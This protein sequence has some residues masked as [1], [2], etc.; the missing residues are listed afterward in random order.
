MSV[1]FRLLRSRRHLVAA[2]LAAGVL[3]SAPGAAIAGQFAPSGSHDATAPAAVAEAPRR[4][5]VQVYANNVENLKTVDAVCPGDWQDLIFAMKRTDPAPDIFLVQQISNRAEL[6]RLLS[7]MEAK[8]GRKYTG[9]IAIADPPIQPARCDGEKKQQTT[10]IIFN[11]DRFRVLKADTWRADRQTAS[12]CENTGQTR[13]TAL[14]LKLRDTL[15]GKDLTV[16]STHWPTKNSGGHPCAAE[17][18]REAAAKVSG[19]GGALMIWGGDANITAGNPGDWKAWYRQTNGDLGGRAGYRDAMYHHC[20]KVTAP[21]QECLRDN[22]TI[23]GSNRI[24]YL[25]ARKPGGMPAITAVHTVGFEEAG[26]ADAH[27]TGGDRADRHYSDHR[28][29]RARIHY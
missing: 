4:E 22:W 12:G 5:Y 8:L 28:A 21:R 6:T 15:A 14:R 27:Y 18:A 23:G 2:V 19:W 26:R 16:A 7:A 24:D 25:W 29:V 1:S 3:L 9:R 11:A 17:N 10:A 13:A 20:G